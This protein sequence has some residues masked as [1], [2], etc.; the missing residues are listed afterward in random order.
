[1]WPRAVRRLL[2][3]NKDLWLFSMMFAIL[4]GLNYVVASE[5]MVL[6]FYVLPAVFSA[7]F[8]GRR[9]ATLTALA[10]VLLV[11][12]TVYLDPHLFAEGGPVSTTTLS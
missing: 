5:G 12:L 3:A 9:H 8:Y 11:I 2:E 4:A 6:G 1:M 10:S 7:Y